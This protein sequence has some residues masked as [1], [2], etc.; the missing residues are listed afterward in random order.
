MGTIICEAE[1]D[2]T[3]K[4]SSTSVGFGGFGLE[5]APKLKKEEKEV[6]QSPQ[7]PNLKKEG[8]KDVEHSPP[9]AQAEEGW[10]R[11]RWSSHPSCRI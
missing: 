10:G 1:G 7:L 6:E 8:E 3:A 9:V 11:R 2:A 4:A 5:Q